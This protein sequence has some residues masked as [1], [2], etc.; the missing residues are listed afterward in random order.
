MELSHVKINVLR[1]V[2]S[3]PGIPVPDPDATTNALSGIVIATS[4]IHPHPSARSIAAQAKRILHTA[5]GKKPTRM[6]STA[7]RIPPALQ[8]ISGRN[9]MTTKMTTMM[10]TRLTMMPRTICTIIIE[11]ITK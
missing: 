4:I 7:T 1:V 5:A 2:T 8:M 10:R 6:M 9:S 3:V 11:V